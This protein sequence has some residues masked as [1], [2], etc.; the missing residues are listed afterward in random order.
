MTSI[1]EDYLTL[2]HKTKVCED[3]KLEKPFDLK[4]GENYFIETSDFHLKV[5][6]SE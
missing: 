6:L 1:N 3:G 5:F 2:V 4:K